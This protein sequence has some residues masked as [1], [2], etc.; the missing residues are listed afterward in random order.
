MFICAR[1]DEEKVKIQLNIAGEAFI[2]SVPYDRQDEAR[3]TE[4]EVN[5]FFRMWRGRFPDKDDRELLAMIAFRFA[6]GYFSLIN[7]KKEEQRRLDEISERLRTLVAAGM[8][9]AE[10]QG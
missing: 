8:A 4:T 10:T 3:F 6:Q 2:L 1:M 5:R 9:D 7:E